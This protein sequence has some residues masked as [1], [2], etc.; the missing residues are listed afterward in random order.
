MIFPFRYIWSKTLK[1]CNSCYSSVYFLQLLLIQINILWSIFVEG[2]STYNL[3]STQ[4]VWCNESDAKTDFY[5][6]HHTISKNCV[7]LISAVPLLEFSKRKKKEKEKTHFSDSSS[8]S[9]V[10][11]KKFIEAFKT[12][13]QRSHP[14]PL[15]TREVWEQIKRQNLKV[16]S[17]ALY[18]SYG[19]DPSYVVESSIHFISIH[20]SSA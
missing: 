9:H 3:T 13:M 11:S 4:G 15:K 16:F 18:P 19:Y 12:R 20:L 2:L 1:F 17:I 14:L 7:F 10:H 5:P 6:H 8:C